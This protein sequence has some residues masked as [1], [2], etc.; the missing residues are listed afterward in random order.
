M[1]KSS[2]YHLVEVVCYAWSHY[3]LLHLVRVACCTWSESSPTSGRSRLL[4]LAGVV[5]YTRRELSPT[6]GHGPRSLLFLIIFLNIR[7]LFI[8]EG[9]TDT[10]S[11]P[12]YATPRWS[13]LLHL[14]GVVSY[15]WSESSPTPDQSRLL[16]LVAAVSCAW[17]ESSPVPYGSRLLHLMGVIS[18]PWLESFPVSYTKDG[19]L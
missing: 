4:H 18:C 15:T 2:S 12:S 5:S 7:A 1:G 9:H 11:D 10:W 19:M 17:L 16:H 13:S 14:V 3:C 6:Y 8:E